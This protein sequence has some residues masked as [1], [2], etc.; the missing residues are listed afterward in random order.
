MSSANPTRSS[1]PGGDIFATTRWTVVLAAG[2]RDAP[3]ADVALEE[4]CRTYWYP[5][6]AYVRRQGHS[7]E[8]A[9]DLTQAF[10]A[11]LLDKNFLE[12]ISSDK[13]KFRAFL[14]VAVKRF[15][16]NEW[17]RAHRQKR[18]GGAQPLSLDWQDADTRYQINPADNLS[19]DKLYDRAWAVTVLERVITRLRDESGVEGRAKLY[20]QLKSFLMA[21]KS[22]IPYAQAAASLNLSEGAVRVAVHRLRRR[23]RELLREEIA[24]TL[25]DPGQADEEMQALF[26]A[27]AEG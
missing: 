12:G 23:Y 22:D 7:R 16:A 24:Q 13:G 26:S 25:S 9:E 18:G 3:Q 6:Y 14:L 5:L 8:D 27:L 1:Q 17:D 4:L 15:L 19:P 2:R 20:E 11:R 10:F 21:G